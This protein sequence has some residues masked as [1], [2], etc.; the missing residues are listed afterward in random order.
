MLSFLWPGAGHL[1][2]GDNSKGTPFVVLSAVCFLISL[3]IIGLVISVPVWLGCAIYTM[4]DSGSAVTRYNDQL[5][6]ATGLPP[7]L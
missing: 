1:Y 5:T 7:T 3:T 2:A 6:E 4:V